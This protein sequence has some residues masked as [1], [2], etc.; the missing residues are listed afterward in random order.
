MPLNNVPV[1][2]TAMGLADHAC[3][4]LLKL[5]TRLETLNGFTPYGSPMTKSVKA[6]LM[7]VAA[8]ARRA[9]SFELGGTP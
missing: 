1:G 4:K 6:P 8:M 3:C 5:Q 2:D 7:V 9:V